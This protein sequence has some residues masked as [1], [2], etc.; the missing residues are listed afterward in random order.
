[1]LATAVE[2]GDDNEGPPVHCD[3]PGIVF[4]ARH[5][6]GC[7][8]DGEDD[9]GVAVVVHPR[10]VA[11]PIVGHD[12]SVTIRLECSCRLGRE[13]LGLDFWSHLYP[14]AVSIF[15]WSHGA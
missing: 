1:M 9:R 6:S 8:G 4:L 15:I 7:V 13:C 10:V 5:P 3:D 11:E 2:K 14:V 12:R